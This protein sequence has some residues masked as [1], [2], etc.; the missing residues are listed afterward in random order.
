MTY[1]Q[2]NEF[3]WFTEKDLI[4]GVTSTRAHILYFEKYLSLSVVIPSGTRVDV[5]VA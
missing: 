3:Q 5:S 1:R 4:V 2:H